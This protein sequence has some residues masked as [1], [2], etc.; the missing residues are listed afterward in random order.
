MGNNKTNIVYF[1]LDSENNPTEFAAIDTGSSEFMDP[2]NLDPQTLLL[3]E[4]V[5][6][7]SGSWGTHS[8]SAGVVASVMSTSSTVYNNSGG[9]GG[10][11]SADE[12]GAAHDTV[13]AYS[14]TWQEITGVIDNVGPVS[15]NIA[16]N[17][18]NITTNAANISDNA[19]NVA[20]VG[21]VSGNIATN[22]TLVG[23][24]INNLSPVS[25]NIGSTASADEYGAAH[26]SVA[27]WSGFDPYGGAGWMGA[28]YR[29]FSTSAAWN[30][31]KSTVDAK[32]ADW[33][34]AATT[35]ASGVTHGYGA[36]SG[37]MQLNGGGSFSAIAISSTGDSTLNYSVPSF[38]HGA[39]K[40]AWR[41]PALI[42]DGANITIPG[43]DNNLSFNLTSG[44]KSNLIASGIEA[45]SIETGTF[46][47]NATSVALGVGN[48]TVSAYA[49]EV[50]EP[51][52]CPIPNPFGYIQ[53][54][55]D[56]VASSDEKN[57]AY[58]NTPTSI[59]SNTDDITWDDTNKYFV[60][61]AA[62]TYEVVGV[63]IL[64]GGSS[65][66]DL[67]VKR[68]GSDVL[69]GSPRVHGTVDPLEHTIRAVFTMTADSNTNITYEATGA[70][71]VNAIT[72]STMTVKRLK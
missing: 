31:T 49:L 28:W 36:L 24:V 22:T 56:D 8:V 29:V 30:S 11:A 70:A 4:T 55:S 19:D 39:E 5:F 6:D 48:I 53:L 57:L 20:V 58:S 68:N 13:Q 41:L 42:R 40:I 66:V 15:A 43:G 27:S 32:E 52:A 17:T 61:A 51:T 14:G 62:G 10:G 7:N 18:G 67:S 25:A 12:Y 23:G 1:I 64:E 33:D 16:T 46:T 69:V 59:I 65:L 71:T 26:D 50:G 35:A 54:D 63:V 37:S 45:K 9:W 3:R 47:S 2:T 60:C 38:D 34:Y 21:G 72:G 44:G